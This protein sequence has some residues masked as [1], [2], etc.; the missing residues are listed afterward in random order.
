MGAQGGL[1]MESN[2]P[3]DGEGM[4]AFNPQGVGEDRDVTA[5]EDGGVVKKLLAE[6]QGFKTPDKGDE[7]TGAWR[8]SARRAR[9]RPERASMALPA[10]PTAR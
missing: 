3:I 8:G 2:Y 6:G 10:R 7:V 9:F 4:A 5:A 1:D